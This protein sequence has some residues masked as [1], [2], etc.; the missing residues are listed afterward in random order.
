MVIRDAPARFVAL[1]VGGHEKGA[2]SGRA[3]RRV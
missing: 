2:P 3:L 1:R